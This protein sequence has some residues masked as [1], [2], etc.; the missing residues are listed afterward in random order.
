MELI[1]LELYVMELMDQRMDHLEH[2]ALEKNQHL[3]HI[4]TLNQ[5][6]DKDI[7]TL[8]TFSQPIH[9]HLIHQLQSQLLLFKPN[10]KVLT[11]KP[12]P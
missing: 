10:Q 8:V 12:L 5:Q 9:P 2:H 7:K 11:K 1:V 6:P 3:F 4:T